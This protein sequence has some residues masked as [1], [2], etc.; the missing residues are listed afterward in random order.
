MRLSLAA[1]CPLS[2]GGIFVESKVVYYVVLLFGPHYKV[3]KGIGY[4][5]WQAEGW[6][7]TLTT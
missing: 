2:W 7:Y 4:L 1:D 3:I 6:A 5:E